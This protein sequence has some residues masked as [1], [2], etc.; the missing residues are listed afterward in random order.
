[1]K[2]ILSNGRCCDILG[3]P[4]ERSIL[5]GFDC[6]TN[7]PVQFHLP[8]SIVIKIQ[9]AMQV[10]PS[11]LQRVLLWIAKLFNCEMKPKT[12]TITTNG[13]TYNVNVG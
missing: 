13:H 1:M 7:K 6:E 11:K 10:K 8:K 4:K 9:E 2:T 12:L 5:T 3:K